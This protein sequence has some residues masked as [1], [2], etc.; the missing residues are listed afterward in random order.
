[1]AVHDRVSE[2][3]QHKEEWTLYG[4]RMTHYFAA[5]KVDDAA[6]KRSILLSAVGPATYKLLRS[7]VD[8]GDLASKSYE[9]L[10]EVLKTHFD[11]KPSII[12]QRYKFNSRARAQG[13]S[14]AVYVAA[15]RALAEHCSYGAS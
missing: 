12:V 8:S 10:V 3:D 1:M 14:I 11:P 7:L 4:E 2:F 9:E 15:L 6:Q 13:E 5:N